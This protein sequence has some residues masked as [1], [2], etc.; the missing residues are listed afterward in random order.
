MRPVVIELIPENI[1]LLSFG[2]NNP[3]ESE[4]VEM[5]REKAFK[6]KNLIDSIGLNHEKDNEE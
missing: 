1:W 5:D 3:K 4:C 6:L 2:G